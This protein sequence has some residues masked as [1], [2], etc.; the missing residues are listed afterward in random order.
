M[1]ETRYR[2]EWRNVGAAFYRLRHLQFIVRTPW[3]NLIVK[4][5]R[6]RLFSERSG[7]KPHLKV[8][9]LCVSWTRLR[10][11]RDGER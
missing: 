11:F 8:L 2:T 3:G 7:G 1:T 10:Y 6:D 9:G 5:W 4:D